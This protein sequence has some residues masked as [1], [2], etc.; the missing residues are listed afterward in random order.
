MFQSLLDFLNSIPFFSS[1]TFGIIAMVIVGSSW[2]LVGL[3]MGD[4]PKKGIEPSL[5]QLGGS[6]FSVGMG[7][8]I[9]L[10]TSAYSTSSLKVT[11]W[12]CLAYF[13][14]SML[15][16][17]ML[18]LMSKAMQLGPNG[19]I[20]SIIQSSL[21]FPFIGGIL[22]FGVEFTWL[23]GMGIFF[24]LSSLLLFA[25]TKDNSKHGSGIKWKLLAFAGMVLAAI[26]QNLH[27]MPSYFEAA[28]GVPS[29]VRSLSAASGLL[30]M[31]IIWNLV[32]MNRE[33][34]DQIRKNIKNLTLWKYIAVLQLFGLIFS[35]TLF[36]PGMNIM[37][38]KGL[39]GMSYP[40]MVG[41]CIVSFTLS[42]IWL[43]KEKIKFIQLAALTVCLIGLCLICTKA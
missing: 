1:L 37:A 26:Q 11:F 5:V 27:T 16:F 22:F 35:Y 10:A 19:V 40:M 18:Q 29:I 39:G 14:G 30:F 12:T 25:F 3:V 4:A 28:R 23:R 31:S 15:N 2:C 43:L 33:R 36:Y 41:S 34:W 9:M 32:Q 8:I 7:L 20:W 17:I 13:V 6:I 42:S 24:L 38:D 21:I